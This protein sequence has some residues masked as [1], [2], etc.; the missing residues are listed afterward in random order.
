[1]ET[2]NNDAAAPGSGLNRIC[3]GPGINNLLHMEDLKL[4]N[5]RLEK[6]CD[7]AYVTYPYTNGGTHVSPKTSDY[8]NLGPPNAMCRHCGVIMWHDCLFFNLFIVIQIAWLLIFYI[9]LC[10]SKIIGGRGI[11]LFKTL[12]S[13]CSIAKKI[14][15]EDTST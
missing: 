3:R 5:V 6:F 8:A 12:V 13:S 14:K 7:A 11:E 1:M 10:I 9:K 15:V 2:D 4:N